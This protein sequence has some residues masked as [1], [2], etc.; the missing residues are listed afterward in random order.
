MKNMNIKFLENLR[1]DLKDYL[2]KLFDIDK[3]FDE[4]EQL[5]G[6]L[7]EYK[8]QQARQNRAIKRLCLS[9]GKDDILK[10]LGEENDR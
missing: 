2:F 5:Q 6:E 8:I 9:L 4:I 1:S 7:T 3:V 10:I